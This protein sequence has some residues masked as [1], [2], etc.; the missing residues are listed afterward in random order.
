MINTK[1]IFSAIMAIVLRILGVSPASKGVKS[2]MG[3]TIISWNIKIPSP[4]LPCGVDISPFSWSNFKTIA[5]LLKLNRNPRKIEEFNG[6]PKKYEIAAVMA[7]VP[8][9]CKPPPRKIIF[10]IDARPFRDNSIP[11]TK[12]RKMIPISES[13]ST[14][15][16]EL[17]RLNA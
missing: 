6:M 16:C 13:N 14:S 10:L 12:R 9:T 17:I 1:R 15:C 3:T 11:M 8:P 7:I 5:V 2:I 4:I